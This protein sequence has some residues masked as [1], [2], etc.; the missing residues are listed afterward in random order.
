MK[1]DLSELLCSRRTRQR[2]DPYA[3]LRTACLAG[4]I[5]LSFYAVTR[6]PSFYEH[7]PDRQEWGM[8]GAVLLSAILLLYTERYASSRAGKRPHDWNTAGGTLH[9]FSYRRCCCARCSSRLVLAYRNANRFVWLTPG[10]A[11]PQG[12]KLLFYCSRCRSS[13]TDGETDLPFVS[14]RVRGREEISGLLQSL[15]GEKPFQLRRERAMRYVWISFVLVCAEISCFYLARRQAVWLILPLALGY[16]LFISLQNLFTAFLTRYYVTEFGI[17]QRIPG[18]Y[19]RYPFNERSTLV[20]FSD[21]NSS[22]WGLYTEAENLLISPVI[23][24]YED[25]VRKLRRA[26]SERSVPEL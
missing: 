21:G 20:R 19:A 23:G 16:F 6:F 8:I 18:G 4:L 1:T 7:G 22:S 26:C 13:A 12:G 25:L 15:K 24:E 5:F 3:S 2:F 17:V 9:A 14:A 10:T 11:V